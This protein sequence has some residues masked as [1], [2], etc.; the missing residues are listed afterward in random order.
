MEELCHIF[1]ANALWTVVGSWIEHTNCSWT[2]KFY[3]SSNRS[4][5][6]PRSIWLSI[7]SSSDRA[8]SCPAIFTEE[9]GQKTPKLGE[10]SRNPLFA[11]RGGLAGGSGRPGGGSEISRNNNEARG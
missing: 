5:W 11:G 1:R 6:K 8:V 4:D 9:D 10:K 3:V 2:R 7:D